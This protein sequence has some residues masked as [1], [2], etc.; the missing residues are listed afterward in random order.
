MYTYGRGVERVESEA[1]ISHAVQ[2]RG[3]DTGVT[4]GTEVTI[5]KVVGEQDNEVWFF[6]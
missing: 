5:P 1:L 4:V 3:A 2:V 6:R